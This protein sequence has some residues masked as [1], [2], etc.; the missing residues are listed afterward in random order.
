MKLR[1][2]LCAVLTVTGAALVLI[3][4]VPSGGF[5]DRRSPST[6]E[7][8]DTDPGDAVSRKFN[9]MWNRGI[10]REMRAFAPRIGSPEFQGGF[11]NEGA[12][13]FA[14]LSVPV[15]QSA[16]RG[17]GR[18]VSDLDKA[19]AEADTDSKRALAVEQLRQFFLDYARESERLGR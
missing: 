14:Q 1:W 8:L 17:V 10:A 7:I 13:A 6:V 15:I 16:E 9:Q 4:W 12:K 3:P 18:R 2:L 11:G 19:I 5:G